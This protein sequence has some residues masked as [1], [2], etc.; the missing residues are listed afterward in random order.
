MP[1]TE[2]VWS[3][4]NQGEAKRIIDAS[5][6]KDKFYEV[7]G[8]FCQKANRKEVIEVC[9]WL[10]ATTA[11]P[12]MIYIDVKH[13]GWKHYPCNYRASV[14]WNADTGVLADVGDGRI[15]AFAR[16]GWGRFVDDLVGREVRRYS[17]CGQPEKTID[18]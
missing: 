8:A 3:E 2:I 12:A 11:N 13:T 14:A 10:P 5:F 18:C 1:T 16:R 15:I 9:V 7:L 17:D 4:W 6:H